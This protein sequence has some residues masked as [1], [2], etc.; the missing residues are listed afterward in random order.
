MTKSVRYSVRLA[1]VFG[2]TTAWFS[3]GTSANAQPPVWGGFQQN[4]QHTGISNVMSNPLVTVSWSTPVD[5][6]PQYTANGSLLAHY[7]S[8]MVTSSNTV[9][10]PVKTGAS[11]GFMIRAF[12]GSNG[13][14][15]WERE[16]R[17]PAPAGGS[18]RPCG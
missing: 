6:N 8:P 9:I 13:S 17:P 5:L 14:L 10:V 3:S 16:P 1:L 18:D 12:N 11:N 15:I 7:A 4:P 2:S